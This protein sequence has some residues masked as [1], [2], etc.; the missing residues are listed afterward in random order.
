MRL[1]KTRLQLTISFLILANVAM[2]ASKKKESCIVDEDCQHTS[3]FNVCVNNLCEHKQVFPQLPLEIGGI[4]ILVA[5]KIMCTMAGVGGGGIVTPLC[6]VFYGFYTKDAVAVS[7]FATFAA[8]FGS[9]LTTFK[10]KHPEKKTTVL[11]DYGLTC[12]MM[13]TTLAGAQIGSFILIVFPT[14]LVQILL[15]VML[16]ALCIQSL[17]KGIQIRR[18]ENKLRKVK[19]EQEKAKASTED[20]KNEVT[21]QLENVPEGIQLEVIKHDINRLNESRRSNTSL[22]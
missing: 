14:P 5:L 17:R 1:Q 15:V 10:Q 6:M 4:F 2:A 16:I 19:A 7:A 20:K 12:I 22:G 11:I 3:K 8:T 9:F 13:P 18:K 21:R